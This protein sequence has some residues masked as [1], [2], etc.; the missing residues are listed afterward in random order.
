MKE[1][2]YIYC[3]KCQRNNKACLNAEGTESVCDVCGHKVS[4]DDMQ[5][6][7]RDINDR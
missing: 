2:I 6:S 1:N 4:V 5:L 3:S 7:M